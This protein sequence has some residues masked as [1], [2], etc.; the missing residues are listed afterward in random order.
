MHK[1][2]KVQRGQIKPNDSKASDEKLAHISHNFSI[3]QKL[4]ALNP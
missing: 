1:Q 4:T 2:E 3:N